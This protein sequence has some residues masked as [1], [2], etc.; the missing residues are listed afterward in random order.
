MIIVGHFCYATFIK[1]CLCVCL[2]VCTYI[3]RSIFDTFELD[4]KVKSLYSFCHIRFVSLNC[5]CTS[6]IA[7]Q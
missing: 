3:W 7:M 1:V 6:N 4:L 2:Y 5:H